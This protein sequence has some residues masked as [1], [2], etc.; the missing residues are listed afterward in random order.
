MKIKVIKNHKYRWVE[1]LVDPED[2]SPSGPD[3]LAVILDEDQAR[4]LVNDLLSAFPDLLN[5]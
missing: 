5:S 3:A 1:L 4:E 2:C